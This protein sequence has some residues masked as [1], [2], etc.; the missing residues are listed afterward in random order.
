MNSRVRAAGMGFPRATG[1]SGRDFG[2]RDAAER[3][4]TRRRNRGHEISEGRPE[5]Y[6]EGVPGNV[7]HTR[8]TGTA[9]RPLQLEDVASTLTAGSQMPFWAVIW[10]ELT[11][12]LS[13]SKSRSFWSA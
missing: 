13:V 12:C 5:H 9:G 8:P 7:V 2:T 10:P 1:A 4:T 3:T 6:L 11:A